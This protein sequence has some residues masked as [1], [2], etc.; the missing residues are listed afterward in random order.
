MQKA[1]MNPS[2]WWVEWRGSRAATPD[3][4]WQG[5]HHRSPLGPSLQ[6]GW[7]EEAVDGRFIG[8]EGA[9]EEMDAAH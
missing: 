1:I 4:H 6:Q 2:S 5:L 3:P 9:V 8:V 7:A